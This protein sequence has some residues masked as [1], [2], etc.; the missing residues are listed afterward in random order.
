MSA[1]LRKE[2]RAARL[3]ASDA[4]SVQTGTGVSGQRDNDK[5]TR[6]PYIP[7]RGLRRAMRKGEQCR[8]W[9]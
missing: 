1:Q 7:C 6:Q 9:N 3:V 2:S 5:Y 4:R 8:N